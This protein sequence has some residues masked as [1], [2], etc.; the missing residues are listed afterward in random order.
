MISDGLWQHSPKVTQLKFLS[1]ITNKVYSLNCIT[2]GIY[3]LT[4]QQEHMSSRSTQVNQIFNFLH[5][6]NRLHNIALIKL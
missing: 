4:S 5:I 3:I 2:P 1:N 6:H